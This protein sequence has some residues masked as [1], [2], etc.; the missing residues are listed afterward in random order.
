MLEEATLPQ[1]S[2]G[3]VLCSTQTL[4]TVTDGYQPGCCISRL[5]TT[6]TAVTSRL[7]VVMAM[8]SRYCCVFRYK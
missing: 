3:Q 1:D 2:L 5:T 4:E 7:L 6:M 8:V